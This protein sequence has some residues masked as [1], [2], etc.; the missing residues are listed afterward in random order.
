MFVLVQVRGKVQSQQQLTGTHASVLV[1]Q[2]QGEAP[3]A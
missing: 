2:E 1:L 3:G